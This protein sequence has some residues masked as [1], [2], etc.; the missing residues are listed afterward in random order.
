M[1][2]RVPCDAAGGVA[3]RPA[4]LNGRLS[5]RGSP[6]DVGDRGPKLNDR[7]RVVPAGRL[8]AKAELSH[9]GALG[10]THVVRHFVPVAAATPG[11]LAEL[12][13]G[14]REDLVIDGPRSLHEGRQPL[15]LG[16]GQRRGVA[17]CNLSRDPEFGAR[18]SF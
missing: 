8:E 12:R 17:L 11:T 18:G 16:S 4:F 7:V 3:L 6:K 5:F 9:V 10:V 2:Q 1:V 14:V 15:A 13:R